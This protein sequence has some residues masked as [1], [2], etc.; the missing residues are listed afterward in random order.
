[1]VHRPYF[2]VLIMLLLGAPAA[3]AGPESTQTGKYFRVICHFK[4]DLV[5]TEALKTAEMVWPVA[6]ELF[7]IADRLPENPREIHVFR[8]IEEYEKR[9]NELTGGQFRHHL[10]FSSWD[11]QASYIFLQPDCSDDT[12]E[13]V[14]LPAPT[15]R[16]IAHEAT[17]L[18][19]YAT[20]PNYRSHPFWLADGAATWVEEQVMTQ[21]G[22][23]P[24]A[25][26]DP[27]MSTLIVRTVA[28]IE[29][30]N[31]PSVTDILQDHID[32]LDQQ[33]RY[34]VSWLLLRFFRNSIDA[35]TFHSIMH[36]AR[37]LGGGSHY[38]ER[39]N[40]FIEGALGEDEMKAID[41]KFEA[42]LR[43][44]SPRWEE[45]YRSLETAGDSWT[46]IAFRDTN[47][48]AWRTDAVGR[49]T[50]TLEGG[51]KILPNWNQQLNLLLGRNRD[52][53]VSVAFVAGGRVTVFD[54]HAKENRWEGLGSAESDLLAHDRWIDFRVEVRG[55]HVQ[56]ALEKTP[57]ITVP[58]NGR[59]MRG[60][61]GLGAQ[62]G[63]AGIWR[64]LRLK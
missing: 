23:S 11:T 20:L 64:N 5:A 53:F 55:D 26:D 47:A 58:L 7:A 46:Q 52:G 51:F 1:M 45:V 21:G 54:Y 14:R 13:R 12:L 60:P 32:G 43:G 17:H 40:A 25:E 36:Q 48:I 33:M 49:D 22:W 31:V 9:D 27:D 35:E 34:G 19:R 30:D 6:T 61:W 16:L 57:I 2:G 24:G 56:V 4:N 50:Y 42:Y 15:R 3:S 59:L 39:L 38:S 44:L 63:S 8:T 28:A 29:K 62:N 18:V 10:A 37:R 41:G